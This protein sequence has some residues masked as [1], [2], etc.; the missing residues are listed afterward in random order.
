[1]RESLVYFLIVA[2]FVELT[3]ILGYVR[4]LDQSLRKLRQSLFDSKVIAEPP[5]P[6][7]ST[8]QTILSGIQA[9]AT[10]PSPGQILTVLGRKASL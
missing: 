6:E 9:A 4:V 8:Q 7:R 1:M 2:G 10:S 3:L 5:S